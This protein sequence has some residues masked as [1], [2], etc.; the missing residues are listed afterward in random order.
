MDVKFLYICG[1][2]DKISSSN[3]FES[4]CGMLVDYWREFSPLLYVYCCI[5]FFLC[6]DLRTI[7][8]RSSCAFLF[9]K[10]ELF[11]SFIKFRESKGIE[12][13]EFLVKLV[14]RRC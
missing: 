7:I 9:I 1:V 5:C 10:G 3:F 12:N 6:T 8:I 13:N 2:S 4:G 14:N 11:F